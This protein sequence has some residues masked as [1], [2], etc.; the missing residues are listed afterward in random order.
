M[1]TTIIFISFH[2]KALLIK[3]NTKSNIPSWTQLFGSILPYSTETLLQVFGK[4][5]GCDDLKVVLNRATWHTSIQS[6]AK[7]K[8]PFL[9][10]PF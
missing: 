7:V 3:T 10:R 2:Q 9:Q 8:L 5:K 1:R 6:Q 4:F